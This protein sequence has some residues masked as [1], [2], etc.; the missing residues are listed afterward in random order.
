MDCL[1]LV[2]FHWWDY[3]IPRYKDA[4]EH[5]SRLREK[6]K[7][8]AIGVTNFDSAHLL[9]IVEAGFE[10]LSI[11][12]QASLLD[13]RAQGRMKEICEAREIRRLGYGSLLGGFLSSRWIGQAEPDTDSLQNRSL[14]KYQL[15]IEDWGGWERFQAFLRFLARLAVKHAV[16]DSGSDSSHASVSAG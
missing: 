9:E 8:R 6:G 7:I 13:R 12:L 15:V 11:Q 10:I 1:D 2:Q 16:V 4:L 5:L 14:K 3:R